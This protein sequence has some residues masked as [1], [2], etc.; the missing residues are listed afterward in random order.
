VSDRRPSIS[1]VFARQTLPE[2]KQRVGQVT[3]AARLA[4]DRLEDTGIAASSFRSGIVE[5]SPPSIGFSGEVELK[6]K[7]GRVP[8]GL[9]MVRQEFPL[10]WRTPAAQIAKWSKDSIFIWV[11]DRHEW[12]ILEGTIQSGSA[13]GTITMAKPR[14]ATCELNAVVSQRDNTATGRPVVKHYG[15]VASNGFNTAMQFRYS[16]EGTEAFTIQIHAIALTDL[17]T[18]DTF[19]WQVI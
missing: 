9:F 6:H 7:L 19:A 10:R 13:T 1:E 8:E 14:I 18:D 12:E 15:Y 16:D 11:E 2:R 4:A 5:W 17:H 3:G